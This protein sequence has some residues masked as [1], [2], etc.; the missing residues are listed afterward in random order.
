MAI[1]N[2]LIK[3]RFFDRKNK[4]EKKNEKF[5]EILGDALMVFGDK[6]PHKEARFARKLTRYVK[7]KTNQEKNICFSRKD[8]RRLKYP[9]KQQCHTKHSI[10]I[11]VWMI[12]YINEFGKPS[13]ETSLYENETNYSNFI[14]PTHRAILKMKDAI[15]NPLISNNQNYIIPI[16]QRRRIYYY[17]DTFKKHCC[18]VN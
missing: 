7:Q 1:Y 13:K 17:M 8:I 15:D 11:I 10:E 5:V 18:V 4:S 16:S 12:K 9:N 2:K 14:L 6:S 3:D